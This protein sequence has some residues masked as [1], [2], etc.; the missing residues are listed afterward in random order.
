VFKVENGTPQM[1]VDGELERF[2][3]WANKEAFNASSDRDKR[4]LADRWRDREAAKRAGGNGWGN[5]ASKL[6]DLEARIA[7]MDRKIQE[8]SAMGANTPLDPE[9]ITREEYQDAAASSG[10]SAQPDL[11]SALLKE[12]LGPLAAVKERAQAAHNAQ[13]E[14]S[15]AR[16]AIASDMAKREGRTGPP[17]FKAGQGVMDF[18]AGGGGG[19]KGQQEF[20]LMASADPGQ[21]AFDFGTSGGFGTKNQGGF[22][23][24]SKKVEEAAK[25]TDADPTPAQIKAGNY[26]KGK[27]TLHGMPISI[28]NAKGSTRS[29]TDKAG[30]PW[31]V[32]MQAHYG[33][34]TGTEGRDKD[35]VDVFIGPNPSGTKAFVVNQIDPSTGKFDEHK[36]M[37]GYDSRQEAIKGYKANYAP[38]W[39][40][41]GN[42]VETTADSL[43]EW[44]KT[45]DT[46]KPA[47]AD[48]FKPQESAQQNTAD[49][50][51]PQQAK[52]VVKDS[53]TV[54][55]P[56]IEPGTP[57]FRLL[58]VA[59]KK[60]VIERKKAERAGGIEDFGDKI[61]GARKDT[62]I[63]TGTTA[64]M[65]PAD[66]RPAWAR[67]Y[68][69]GEM[70]ASS[71]PGEVG[72]FSIRDLKNT[73]WRGQP[74]TATDQTFATREEA[75]KAVPLLAV[76]RNH[77]VRMVKVEGS[78][79]AEY[80]Y[81]I[82]RDVTDH[83]K[84]Q[85]VKQDFP[86]REDALKFMASHAADIIDTKTS[87]REELFATPEKSVRT[88][89]ERRTGPATADMFQNDFGFR[90][91]EFGNWMR[92]A[93]DGKERQEVLNHAYDGLHDLADV[94]GVPTK[95]MSL[96]G[97]LGLAF[98]ARGQ[99][100]QGS[101]AHYERDYAVINLTK[102]SGA[103]S[104][105]H[106]WFHAFDHYLGRQDG[107][108]AGEMVKN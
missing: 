97:E 74:R 70:V 93:G 71:T 28:E 44:L 40:G 51:K 24:T 22:D 78:D 29:G 1:L 59:D 106:E 108:A 37:L 23:F 4:D 100:L 47:K 41:L 50:T 27:V 62:S 25:K 48:D 5:E 11:F 64:T 105:A 91:V 8:Q 104:L 38:D 34:F 101:K 18:G 77:K 99:G 88:G 103:G 61:G 10:A 17:A 96:N 80:T 82:W 98:G 107:K 19:K 35:H 89:K 56:A 42:M 13:P 58:P 86:T 49:G 84:V 26:A 21:R 46:K 81:S 85:V 87:Y 53:L 30:K 6:S 72:R 3:H 39:K 20:S 79:P 76:S 67:R 102:M 33:Y 57:D 75:E 69:I 15:K 36:V 92:Q 52:P 12:P 2:G 9:A 16:E 60:V 73:D 7:K 65:K 14:G 66:S 63:K 54:T 94:L 31:S 90:G 45:E 32:E 83:K 43:R 68:E 55:P 95:A